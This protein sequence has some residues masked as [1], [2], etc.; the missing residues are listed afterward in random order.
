MP[1]LQFASKNSFPLNGGHLQVATNAS[2]KQETF[3]AAAPKRG[4]KEVFS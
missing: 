3:T 2:K 4:S 1:F